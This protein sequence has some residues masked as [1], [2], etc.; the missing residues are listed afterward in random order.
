MRLAQLEAAGRLNEASA[1][2]TLRAQ[3]RALPYVRAAWTL[4]ANGRIEFDSDEGD[5]GASLADRDYFQIYQRQPATQFYL[6]KPVRSR[7]V[8]TWLISAARPL[9][10]TDGRLRGVVVAALFLRDGTLLMRSPLQDSAMGKS[11]ADQPLFNHALEQQPHGDF[12]AT[13]PADGIHRLHSYRSLDLATP[14]VLE[15]GIA[16]ETV[17]APWR[18]TAIVA[19]SV[20][21]T[22][23]AVL[24][25]AF[26]RLRRLSGKRRRAEDQAALADARL[27]V[28]SDASGL[29]IWDWTLENDGWTV[30]PNHYSTLGLETGSLQVSATQWR[31]LIHPDDRE[32]AERAE[33]AQ[34][35]GSGPNDYTVRLRHADG[36]YRW[37][38]MVARVVDR[39]NS[40]NAVRLAGVRIDVTDRKRG[41]LKRDE[42]FERI[43]DAFVALDNNWCYTFVNARAGVIFDRNPQDLIDKHIWTEFPEGRGQRFHRMYEEA[44]ATQT[45][46]TAEEYYPP[47]DRRFENRIYP[48]PSGLTIYSHDITDLTKCIDSTVNVIHNEIKYKADVVREYLPTP[49][50]QCHASELNQVIMNLVV[51]AA[52]AIDGPGGTITI[53][54]G[55]Q[56]D[57]VWF[58]VSDNGSGIHSKNLGRI[59]DPFFTTKP[60]GKGTGL[61]LSISYG[62]VRKHH[63]Q[64]K[65]QSEVGKG[66]SFRV[67]L[68]RVQPEPSPAAEFELP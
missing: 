34:K 7:S 8:G 21:A 6:G 27:I 15:V 2:E 66:T 35:S 53:K 43:S 3:I 63:G 48:S 52:Q 9:R 65:V 42:L 18:N 56:G 68:P 38:H 39:D 22:V 51:N 19:L 28:A 49:A 44:L 50:V 10:H 12:E 47:Y 64:I 4:D 11:F 58:Q 40:G 16:A 45:P 23:C 60:V 67:I 57:N 20:W 32:A 36:S 41:E 13:T 61:G 31:A 25:A 1:R 62:I 33:S 59:F 37:T 17:L 29:V 26:W 54:T 55:T 5:I 24:W 30:S 14:L 46:I